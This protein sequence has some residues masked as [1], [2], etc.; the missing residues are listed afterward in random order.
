VALRATSAGGVDG[1]SGGGPEAQ[2]C[3]GAAEILRTPAVS[4]QER[5]GDQPWVLVGGEVGHTADESVEVVADME[6]FE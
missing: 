6:L 1:S 3:G 4:Q 2:S 5:D